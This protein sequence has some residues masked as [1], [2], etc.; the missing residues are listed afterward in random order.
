MKLK[1]RVYFRL[2]IVYANL[3]K[4]PFKITCRL[5]LK[6]KVKERKNDDDCGGGGGEDKSYFLLLLMLI[7]NN[8]TN[9]PSASLK[10]KP[11]YCCINREGIKL[12]E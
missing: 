6:C 3:K 5:N 7:V 9:I 4:N 12:R 1:H 8:S 11:G 10:I 2:V